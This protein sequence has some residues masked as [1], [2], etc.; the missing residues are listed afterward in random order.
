MARTIT[1]ANLI[2][3]IRAATDTRSARW[4]DATLTRF[5]N[6]SIAE[7][8]DLIVS[9]CHDHYLS[10]Q[11]ISVVSGT[12]SYSLTSSIATFYK[13]HGVD[14]LKTDG[15]YKRMDP[16]IWEERHLYNDVDTDRE[17][18]RYRLMG[19]NL[20]IVPKPAWSGTIK[21]W[22]IPAPTALATGT[23]TFDGVAGWEQYVITDCAI[24]VGLADEEDVRMHKA[25]KDELRSRI[26]HMAQ[27]RDRSNPDKV[28][29]VRRERLADVRPWLRLP[30]P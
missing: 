1:L 11:T 27:T 10:S 7:L 21:V 17:Q 25:Q 28:R 12:D 15:T 29:D 4:P 6:E 23:D 22:Y 13:A 24:K 14:V 3:D 18:A 19:S 26:L 9:A 5:I 2:T 30:R 20:I 8:Y 16:F